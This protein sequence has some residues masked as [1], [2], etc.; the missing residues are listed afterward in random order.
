MADISG[1]EVRRMIER[2]N[3]AMRKVDE[4]LAVADI[5]DLASECFPDE[6]G[7]FNSGLSK[8][9]VFVHPFLLF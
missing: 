2:V 4:K 6:R 5:I 3:K 8:I 7:K 1:G 9:T